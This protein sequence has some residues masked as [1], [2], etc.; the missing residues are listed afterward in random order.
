MIKQI[1]FLAL[2][3][4]WSWSSLA[5]TTDIIG[6]EPNTTPPTQTTTTVSPAQTENSETPAIT[7]PRRISYGLSA[8]TQYSR[9]F[10]TTTFLEPSVLFPVTKRFS[11]FASLT[12]LNTFGPNAAFRNG[13]VSGAGNVS[14]GNQRYILNAGGNYA[15]SDRLNL[16]GSVWRDLTKNP[17]PASL[18]PYNPGGTSGLMLRANYKITEHLSVSGGFRY[19]NGNGYNNYMYNPAAPFGF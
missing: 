4:G 8:G 16:T 19:G 10:G 2:L 15:V 12:F 9:L 11:G 7:A 3:L 18:N 6:A 17:M 14:F 1:T 13:E 5:Q